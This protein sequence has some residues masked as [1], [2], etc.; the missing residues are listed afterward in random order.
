MQS[1]S[2]YLKY[3]IFKN[4]WSMPGVTPGFAFVIV[5]GWLLSTQAALSVPPTSGGRQSRERP[6]CSGWQAGGWLGAQQDVKLPVLSPAA[7]PNSAGPLE[8]RQACIVLQLRSA[9]CAY[10][11]KSKPL[12]RLNSCE[13]TRQNRRVTMMEAP[14]V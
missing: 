9:I 4:V 3:K 10:G 2:I 6:P 12:L 7:A 14:F 8:L 1:H 13:Y 5:S 11:M